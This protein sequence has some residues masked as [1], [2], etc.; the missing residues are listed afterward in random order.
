VAGGRSD[1]AEGRLEI[2]AIKVRQGHGH[3]LHGQIAAFSVKLAEA[4]IEC[5]RQRER[6][7]EATAR[8]KAIEKLRERRWKRHVRDV[9]REEQG[10]MDE[11]AGRTG[12]LGPKD[13][14]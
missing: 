10:A 3:W 7:A 2:A 14:M 9:R 6:L 11:A 13:A 8:L 12:T 1:R 5:E 4:R